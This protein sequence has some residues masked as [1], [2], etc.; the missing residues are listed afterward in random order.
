MIPLK[1]LTVSVLQPLFFD[2]NLLKKLQQSHH[3]LQ[4]LTG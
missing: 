3:N 1:T 2:S 4:K